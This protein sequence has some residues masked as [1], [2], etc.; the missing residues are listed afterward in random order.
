[1]ENRLRNLS[2]W[3]VLLVFFGLGLVQQAH[4]QIDF[5][6]TYNGPDTIFVGS[7][8][9]APLDWGA[10]QTVDVTCNTAGCQ[11]ITFELF[12]ISGGYSEGD[13]IGVGEE[14]VVTYFA[15]DDD[16]NTAF[17]GFRLYFVD[18]TPPVFDNVPADETFDCISNVPPVPPTTDLSANDNCPAPGSTPA[19]VAITFDG[20]TGGAAVCEAGTI[21]RTWTATDASGNSA[22]YTQTITVDP[23]MTPPV[24]TTSPVDDTQD[25]ATPDYG[26]WLADQMA[27]FEAT[28]DGCGDITYTNDAPADFSNNCGSITV[29][30]TATDQ[31]GNAVNTQATFSTQDTNAPVITPPASTTI[32][33]TCDAMTDPDAIIQDFANTLTV[34]ENCTNFTWTDNFTGLTNGACPGTGSATVTY[35][36]ADQ[37]GNTDDITITFN[38]TDTEGPQITTPPNNPSAS[39]DGNVNTAALNAWLNT[40]GG[41]TYNDACS[42]NADITVSFTLNGNP[43]TNQDVEN[44]LNASIS[45]N[46][47]GEVMVEFI[48]T[49]ACGNSTPAPSTFSVTDNDPPTWNTVPTDLFIACDGTNDPQGQIQTWLDNNGNGAAADEC[50]TPTIT[51]DFT[52]LTP[53]CG[54]AGTAT[55][56]FTATDACGNAAPQTVTVNVVD[57]VDPVWTVD[58]MDMSVVCD[59]NTQAAYD[60]W[61]ASAGGGAA[62][63]E[64][65]TVTITD[66]NPPLADACDPNGTVV[67]FTATDECGG[68][69]V[70]RTATFTVTD[71]I[72]PVW[73]T[74]PSN[75]MV[76]CNVP[77]GLDNAIQTWLGNNGGGS[78]TDNCGNVS[79]SN[80]FANNPTPCSINPIV[81]TFTATD[82]CGNTATTTA[83]LDVTDNAGPVWDVNPQPLVLD[84]DPAVDAMALVQAWLDDNG[85]GSASDNCTGPIIFDNN[86]S[87]ML[88]TC[89]SGGAVNVSFT[90]RDICGNS[91]IAIATITINDDDAP[92]IDM[93]A[94]DLTAECGDPAATDFGAWLATQGGAVA[95]D[96]CTAIEASDWD[97]VVINDV[98]GCGNTF[99]RTVAFTVT[100]DCGNSSTTTATYTLVDNTPPVANPAPM[101]A[102][103]LCGGGN[104]QNALNAW[105]DAVGGAMLTDCG[106]PT[107]GFF[108]YTTASG[109]SGGFITIGN[110]GDYPQ[111][112]PGACDF[113]VNVVWEFEDDCGN[114]GT[115]S[116]TFTIFDDES[117]VFSNVPADIT[118]N[119]DDPMGVVNPDVVDNCDAFPQ[120]E[121][122]EVNTPTTC[123]QTFTLTR[124]WTATDDCGNTA[125]TQQ[126][127]TISDTEAPQFSNGDPVL[128]VS[129]DNIP[130]TDVTIE[131]NCDPNIDIDFTEN[132][133]Q[134]SCTHEFMVMRTWTATDA[135]G[136]VNT[137]EQTINVSDNEAPQFTGPAAITVSC[138]QGIDPAVTGSLGSMMDNCDDNPSVNFVDVVTQGACPNE[139]TVQRTWTATDACG[140]VSIPFIQMITVID[141]AAPVFPTPAASISIECDVNAENAFQDWVNAFGFAQG[142]DNCS[143]AVDLERH[144]WVPGSY[145]INDPSTFPGDPVNGFDSANCPSGTNGVFR[146]ETVDF[147]F[148]DECGNA[149]A[150]TATFTV[151]DTQAPTFD[152]CPAADII[153]SAD[154]VCEGAVTL[155]IPVITENCNG[156]IV[157][158]YSINNGARIMADPT[159]A[160]TENFQVGIV[161]VT[162]FATDCAG[163]EGACTFNVS[164][165]DLEPP[166]IT[167]P[168][169]IFIPVDPAQ[170]C[171]GGIDVTL[172]L[173]VSVDDNCNYPINVQVQPT[174]FFDR[175]ITFSY[176]ANYNDY[177]A[178]DKIITF[179]GLAANAVGT[180]VP[181]SVKI[182]GD[183]DSPEAYY[184][185]FGEDG[186]LLGT[187]EVGQPNVNVLIPGDCGAGILPLITTQID[188]PT[189]LYN[190]YASDG[191]MVLNLVS[192]K[193]FAAP[194]PGGTGDGINPSCITFP[195][196][197]PNGLDDGRSQLTVQLDLESV[198]PFYYTTGATVTPLTQMQ[199][200]TIAPTLTF[201]AGET[202]VFYLL[203][204]AAGNADTCSFTVTVA[205]DVPPTAVC[206]EYTIYVNPSGIIPYVLDAET[207]VNDGSF[208]NCAIVDYRVYPDTFTCAEVGQFINVT[209]VVTDASGNQDSCVA[210]VSVDVEKA[211]PDYSIGFCGDDT[212]RLFANPP[213]APGFEYDYSWFGPNGF[214]STEANPMIPNATPANSGE[215]FVEISGVAGC[216]SFGAVQVDVAGQPDVPIV[217]LSPNQVCENE[218]VALTTTLVGGN[219]VTYN[220]YQGTAPNGTLITSST[221]PSYNLLAPQDTSSY[222]VIVEVDGCTS[223]ASPTIVVEPTP[224]PF[225]AV[226]EIFIEVCEGEEIMLGTPVNGNYNYQWVG[227]NGFM[228]NDQNPASFTATANRSGD[229]FLIIGENGCA[230]DPAITTVQV[231]PAPSTPV[232]GISS[233][234]VCE[235]SDVVLSANITDGTLYTWTLPDAT[236][237]FTDTSSLMIENVTLGASGN[238]NVMVSYGDCESGLSNNASLFVE[239]AP[240]AAADNNG[241]S[242]ENQDIQLSATNV[243]GATYTWSGPNGFTSTE[244][245]PIISAVAGEYILMVTSING[246]T[247]MDTTTVFVS[248]NPVITAVSNTGEDCVDGTEDILLVATIAPNDTLYT[249]SWTGPNGF[250]STD[251]VAVIPNG[252]ATDNGEYTLVVTN[253]AGCISAPMMTTVEVKNTPA[254]PV[255]AGDLTVCEGES[256]TLATTPVTGDSVAYIWMTPNGMVNTE[257]PSLTIPMTAVTD[258]G[259]YSLSVYVN[260]C[261]SLTSPASDVTIIPALATPTVNGPNALCEGTSLQLTTDF[262]AG[263]TYIWEGPNGFADTVAAPALVI[264]NVDENNEGQYV[265]KIIVEDCES[266]ISAPYNV[267]INPSP[268]TPVLTGPAPICIDATGAMM[269]LNVTDTTTTAGA[270]Y[271]WFDANTNQLVFGPSTDPSFTLTDFTGYTDGVYEFYAVA[272]ATGCTSFNSQPVAV[273][274]T[275][276][277]DEVANAGTDINLC[278]GTSATL[279]ATLPAVGDGRWTQT[280]GPAV[281]ITDPA[282]PNIT[283]DG[284][285][286][287][288][289]YT[290]SWILSNGICGDYSNDEVT[291]RIDVQTDVA[292]AGADMETCDPADV[293]LGATPANV[294][295]TGIWTQTA[296]QAVVIEDVNDPNT[297]ISGM[298]NGQTYTF[299]WTVGN[300]GCGDFSSDEVTINVVET[301]EAANAGTDMEI[302]GDGEAQLAAISASTTNGIWT[303]DSD[304]TIIDPT[305]PNSAVRGLMSGENTFVWTVDAGIC[306]TTTDEIVIVFAEAPEAEADLAETEFA[307]P[308]DIDLLVNDF[309]PGMITVTIESEPNDGNVFFTSEGVATYTPNTNF[310]GVD[311]FTYMICSDACPDMC[312]EATVTI[313][314]GA[315]APCAAPT[316]ITPNDDGYNDTFVVPCLATGDYPNNIVSIFNQ[317]G[318]EVFRQ[319]NYQNDW[320]GTYKG[321]DLPVG[322]YFFVVDF[323]NG[324]E[325]IT[326][327]LVI[328]R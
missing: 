90:A 276:I 176:D 175:F 316:I 274:F 144:A 148:I 12:A 78:A 309:T 185:V 267:I 14:V 140:N 318:D 99:A 180:T 102:T 65:G 321:D 120:V 221:T 218:D 189:P 295:N 7:D 63:D 282:D 156:N 93:P 98:P 126:V 61:R 130:T 55:V 241:P 142:Q 191:A 97:F 308:V 50:T 173:P 162:Y 251:S 152:N 158:E 226:N 298:T 253:S 48:F 103:E 228:S 161:S 95:T 54:T 74:N 131:D 197:T 18:N 170:D 47:T 27:N 259:A 168:A 266:E 277:P 273:E 117:P 209:L 263:A 153:V 134:G 199:Q 252:T 250:A 200:P 188:I 315:D 294:N 278:G 179:T 286:A 154:G 28:D 85:G 163:N 107:L 151:G 319:T 246:C 49:D 76:D 322:T 29:T 21:T 258:A 79:F 45:G 268:L 279:S 291:V 183:A 194:A 114:Q 296:G 254:M 289:T 313:A 94:M 284:L 220:W 127:I 317:W 323:Q 68:N 86:Y 210:E 122:E 198:T 51:N 23:D 136:N 82:D 311:E 80:D 219:S 307:T 248:D 239:P 10:P 33:L 146:S 299:T 325:P 22:Q 41:A 243:P 242:C 58:P 264:F 201:N 1:M 269:T 236:T 297:A 287:N 11:I 69:T 217:T 302:C 31:C 108:S 143:L 234:S 293:I 261:I 71:D 167:C 256:L 312:A 73:N 109:A 216:Q 290:F 306:G 245:N 113:S 116:A 84:C 2:C 75:L 232:L 169:D 231:N 100:D 303:T 192:N 92:T 288:E 83:E 87:G 46:C 172:P 104:D 105:I 171:M 35:I 25:C 17:F 147:V 53:T 310:A 327:F 283:I 212:L 222:Y 150:S 262:I 111:I 285:L 19:E 196:G 138:E 141:D 145:D 118:I 137:F 70:T 202:E 5:T 211:R 125:T 88:P 203:N 230:S 272:T 280:S 164:I 229:Y 301:P 52:G 324:D 235:G 112:V 16:N 67:I 62:T 238:Y 190:I 30:F 155:P 224:I 3:V 121:M 57:F 15:E 13:P 184:S 225:A 32:D 247:N 255:I 40:A 44:A 260:G 129:C 182:E 34:T 207:E 300:D 43:A 206:Q 106:N 265:V 223:E 132:I 204:D 24:I 101:D 181:I 119:C 60:A 42:D 244:E 304:A 213:F 237:V 6:F 4:A 314:V 139:S 193:T 124:T 36:V 135:C 39:C 149:A 123:P 38:V 8:C 64:C 159:V 270:T 257:T 110:Y 249:Y 81:V 115:T 89:A 305:S 205:D 91:T 328:E 177:I 160:I 165:E 214:T 133:V 271:T 178:D 72:D 227:P 56:T 281:V 233:G 320:R 128:N 166:T 66:N 292:V 186:T 77:G 215:Y 9:T 195:N 96:V 59:A 187:T 26:N 326:G 240:L 174:A 37:C 20:E 157:F 208:D 275:T